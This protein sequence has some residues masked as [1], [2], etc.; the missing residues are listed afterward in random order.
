MDSNEDDV[1]SA[2]TDPVEFFLPDDDDFDHNRGQS[3]M[4]SPTEEDHLRG[5]EM[6]VVSE[7]KSNE[8]NGDK[9]RLQKHLILMLTTAMKM[10]RRKIA[11]TMM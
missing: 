4:T 5:R 10:E 1:D 11:S 7:E 8:R 2:D 9:E 3:R 6:D